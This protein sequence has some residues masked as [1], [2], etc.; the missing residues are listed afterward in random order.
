MANNPCLLYIWQCFFTG[1]PSRIDSENVYLI[2]NNLAG[3]SGV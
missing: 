3:F 1:D 2:Q